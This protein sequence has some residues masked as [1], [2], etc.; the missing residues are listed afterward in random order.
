MSKLYS[1]YLAY[2]IGI[3]TCFMHKSCELATV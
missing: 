3:L 2:F 1:V